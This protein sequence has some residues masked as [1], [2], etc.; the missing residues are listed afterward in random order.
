MSSSSTNLHGEGKYVVSAKSGDASAAV[1][2]GWIRISTADGVAEVI[3]HFDGERGLSG[4]M[5]F[6]NAVNSAIVEH[7]KKSV[8]VPHE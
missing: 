3:L 2:G 7:A 8:S 6:A 5:D 4:M 1:N